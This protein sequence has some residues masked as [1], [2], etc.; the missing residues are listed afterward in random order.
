MLRA[1]ELPRLATV[2]GLE[3]DRGGRVV[4]FRLAVAYAR[5]HHQEF[6]LT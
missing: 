1:E 4:A 2:L 6:R 3:D 5:A